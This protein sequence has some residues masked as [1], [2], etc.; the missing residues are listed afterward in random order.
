MIYHHARLRYC[1]ETRAHRAAFTIFE[2]WQFFFVQAKLRRAEG[3][4][5]VK[6]SEGAKVIDK[7]A[8]VRQ[9][10]GA[11]LQELLSKVDE[12]NEYRLRQIYK[13]VHLSVCS[14]AD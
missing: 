3:R 4:S 10:K 12:T 2:L 11:H 9:P 13:A 5:A 1:R 14:I 7:A 6:R 8:N